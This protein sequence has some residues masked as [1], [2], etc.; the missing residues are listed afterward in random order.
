MRKKLLP[1]TITSLVGLLSLGVVGLTT[2]ASSP[3]SEDDGTYAKRE[4]QGNSELVTLSDIDDDDFDDFDDFDDIDEVTEV[5][6]ATPSVTDA[7]DTTDTDEAT[8]PTE[9][10]TTADDV[11]VAGDETSEQ[12]LTPSLTHDETAEAPTAEADTAEAAEEETEAAEEETVEP[13]DDDETVEPE[14]D[15]DD[16]DD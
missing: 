14:D 9:E 6:E 4:E 12:D 3:L 8:A 11:M 1:A 15:E 7:T 10:P 2:A 16:E 13:E 5:T